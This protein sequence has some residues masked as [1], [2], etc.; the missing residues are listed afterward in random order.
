MGQRKLV[1]RNEGFSPKVQLS[2]TVFCAWLLYFTDIRKKHVQLHWLMNYLLGFSLRLGSTETFYSEVAI[3]LKWG[4]RQRDI[5]KNPKPLFSRV[6]ERECTLKPLSTGCPPSS[7][8]QV[9]SEADSRTL[10]STKPYP[11]RKCVL[12]RKCASQ[13]TT[14][15][16]TA[17]RT[18]DYV[19]WLW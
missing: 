9:P 16:I 1:S 6:A 8:M 2:P 11:T 7:H 4:G 5:G 18:I 17:D 3:I 15:F 13:N 14:D 10:V 19:S 12:R